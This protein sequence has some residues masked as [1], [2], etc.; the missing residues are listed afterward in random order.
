MGD[1]GGK[2]SQLGKPVELQD[3]LGKAVIAG[4]G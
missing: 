2:S 1:A 4:R 3:L